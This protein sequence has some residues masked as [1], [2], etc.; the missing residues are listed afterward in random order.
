M[1][2][3]QRI[4]CAV[5][6]SPESHG[7]AS[8]AAHLSRSLAVPMEMLHSHHVPAMAAYGRA[9]APDWEVWVPGPDD[10]RHELDLWVEEFRAQGTD[11]VPRYVEG[12]PNTA[13]ARNTKPGD[14]LVVGTH[15]AGDL[16]RMFL[17]STSERIMRCAHCPTLAI[18]PGWR[19]TAVT[20]ILA[21]I[22]FSDASRHV[23][24]LAR[25]VARLVGARV[26]ALHVVHDE[27]V[28]QLEHFEV[29]EHVRGDVDAATVDLAALLEGCPEVPSL[30]RVGVPHAEI[31]K[32]AREIEADV[33]AVGL[34]G[35]NPIEAALLGST[36]NRVLRHAP[37][38]VLVTR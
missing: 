23:L 4:L 18:P 28:K 19:R 3:I 26:Q 9:V 31:V 15:E 17:G 37:C 12:P 25:D 20:S 7:A 8:Y 36:A 30:V 33:I 14:L 27:P 10:E 21:G 1:N 34:H 29:P 5:D 13:S 35:H 32:M 22:D 2:R 16:A 11:V 24:A 6:F 38:P